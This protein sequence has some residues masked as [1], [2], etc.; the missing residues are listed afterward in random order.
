MQYPESASPESQLEKVLHEGIAMN[1]QAVLYLVEARA[2]SPSLVIE[3]I[4]RT[5]FSSKSPPSAA[6][7]QSTLYRDVFDR[8]SQ[9]RQRFNSMREG[10]LTNRTDALEGMEKRLA[11]LVPLAFESILFLVLHDGAAGR[12]EDHLCLSQIIDDAIGFKSPQKTYS[13]IADMILSS[14]ESQQRPYVQDSLDSISTST[15]IKLL[16]RLIQGVRTV[17][18][19]DVSQASRWIR[20]IVQVVLDQFTI[21]ASA[22]IASATRTSK[23]F[24]ALQMLKAIVQQALELARSV[25]RK[26]QPSESDSPLQYPAEE[27][28][29]LATTLFNLSIDL[30]IMQSQNW[31]GCSDAEQDHS[32]KPS[33]QSRTCFSS[34][35]EPPSHPGII[36]GPNPGSGVAPDTNA[37]GTS[38]APN[39]GS[40]ILV[41][42]E[43]GNSNA[44]NIGCESILSPQLWASLA[45]ELADLLNTNLGS[46][47]LSERP[48]PLAHGV[49][50]DR[51]HASA[52]TGDRGQRRNSDPEYGDGGA[53]AKVLRERCRMLG[54]EV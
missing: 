2:Y 27:L 47:G 19:Y 30:H 35:S 6:E 40:N 16:A 13:L 43:D 28:E 33:Q 15:A 23:D 3:D 41:A 36:S 17:T 53:L 44:N 48:R 1:V 32:R 21:G 52:G 12:P 34:K 8:Y 50:D 39:L 7:I 51:V 54:W 29:W 31:P 11:G 42:P 9:S 18:G 14:T 10:A 24:E 46:A 4:P 26:A 22:I 49:T 37:A 20:C 38:F 5:S 25:M 45:V